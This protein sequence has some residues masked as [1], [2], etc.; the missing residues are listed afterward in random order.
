MK[1]KKMIDQT[2]VN[3]SKE[4]EL[5]DIMRKYDKESNTRIWEGIPKIV[6]SVFLGL[7]SLYCI[8]MTLFSKAMPET[9]L[10][11]FLGFIIIA[12]FLNFP[13]NKKNV[14]PNFLPWY[15][16]VL[17][18]AGAFCFF[19]FA[20]NAL[21]IINLATRIEPLH[22]FLGIVGILVLCELCR[23][24]VGIPILCIAAALVIYAYFNQMSYG[25]DFIKA[26]Q[27]VIYKLFYTTSGVIGT[28]TSV[29]YTYIVLFIIFGAFLE[30]TG[31]AAYF[32][33]LANR[34]AGWSS[35]GPA[36][37]AVI[38][39][40]LCGMVSG[41][42][43]G[44][45]V[46]TGSVTIP[47]MKKTGYKPEFA[48]A[49][50]AAASTGGQIM[51]PIMGA[52]AF[53][54]A[55]YMNIP[56]AQVALKAIL[57]AVLYFAG[58]FIAVHLEAK[59]LGLKGISK[60]EMPKWSYLAKNFYL[61]LPLVVLVWLVSSGAKT[62]ASAAAISI[63]F[64]FAVGFVNMLTS[65]LADR[66]PGESAGTV[67]GA[68]VKKSFFTAGEA[69]VA[70][71]KGSVTVAV[72]C[73][74]AGIIAGCITV[75]GLAS[76]LI[77]AIVQVAGNATIIGLLLTML[78]C[79]VLGMGVPT[80][81]NYCIMAS[82]CAPILTQ[83]GFRVVA[84]HFFVFYFGIVADITPPVALA[85][86]AGSAIAKSNP[87]KT[88]LNATKLAIAA[89]IVPYI[90]AY[91]PQML[92]ENL[93]GWYD[94]VL[95]VISALLGLFSIAAA[96]NGYLFRKIPVVFR[97]LLTGGGLC[98]MIP[99]WLTDVIGFAVLA[100]VIAIQYMKNKKQIN[101]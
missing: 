27:T 55:E 89:F 101:A 68:T 79:I 91:S 86:Y 40:A 41:S 99:G 6:I 57:P 15:D 1:D 28:P 59:K 46:T 18:L 72:A 58:I 44:N 66:Q 30:R 43:V 87:M 12:G 90:F 29:C 34:L 95:I 19:Y 24:C 20:F 7:F 22:V 45:T 70:G 92:M 74:M 63:L 9:R 14:R 98:M 5:D 84:A 3:S 32:I 100:L 49:V 48:G 62:M 51:P 73:A 50:E 31:I 36:K 23:R 88:G 16:V 33:A 47:M 96:L 26:T 54:M 77:N 67:L 52:A 60:E 81:A 56:Y 8:Y 97:L 4:K 64:A 10:T 69:L 82:T 21:P 76:I 42:S 61:L 39:S 94:V 75:T 35:G 83:L 13:A 25:A 80:T 65:A 17:M 53:L 11:L 93:A 2:E 78:C 37:V 85:A 71:A 38:S